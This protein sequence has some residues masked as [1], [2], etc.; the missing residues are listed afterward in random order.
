MHCQAIVCATSCTLVFDVKI[1]RVEGGIYFAQSF[2]VCMAT[3]QGQCLIEE[4]WY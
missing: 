2:H 3:I 1:V 4:I